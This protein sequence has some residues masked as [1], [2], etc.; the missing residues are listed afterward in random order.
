MAIIE[1]SFSRANDHM[2]HFKTSS[3]PFLPLCRAIDVGFGYV[4]LTRSA[5]RADH[6]CETFSF[7]SVAPIAPA[8]RDLGGGVT[9]ANQAVVVRHG[10]QEFL[11]GPDA[12]NDAGGHFRRLLDDSY[13]TTPQY[14]AL[15]LGALHYMNLPDGAAIEVLGIGLPTTHFGNDALK[16]ALRSQ[17][18]G[19]HTIPGEQPGTTKKVEVRSLRIF[20]QVLGSLLEHAARTD[21]N[22]SFIHQTHLTVDVGFG[23]LLW[24]VSKGTQLMPSRSNGTMGGISSFLELI[25]RAVD[26]QVAADPRVLQKIDDALRSAPA[27][28]SGQFFVNGKSYR[29]ADFADRVT[30]AA[31]EHLATLMRSIGPHADLD[32]LYLTGGG[33][34]LYEGLLKQRFPTYEVHVDRSMNQQFN[35]VRGFQM[36][37]ERLA[38]AAT[39]EAA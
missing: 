19:T 29:I 31:N 39:R 30:A 2:N 34:F 23:T 24:M 36:A 38:L 18:V 26:P 6:S 21:S 33:A 15:Y 9:K 16:A 20:P 35:N 28:P 5:M 32:R 12:L 25:A 1:G 10:G 37:V 7:P 4:K 14:I 11:V 22:E 13:F 8:Y 3:R 27:S 17:L